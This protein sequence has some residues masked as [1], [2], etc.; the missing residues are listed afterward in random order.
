MNGG[1]DKDGHKKTAP[2][3][4]YGDRCENC[5]GTMNPRLRKRF[6][7]K[8]C[9][10]A[11]HKKAHAVGESK[12]KEGKIKAA[13]LERSERLQKVAK[14]LGDRKAYS[15]RDIII[16]CDV[17][18]VSAIADELREAKNGFD[19]Q[20]TQIKKDRWEY[21]MIGGFEH[22]KRISNEIIIDKSRQTKQAIRK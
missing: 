19:I 22:L 15:T 13:L 3:T 1:E 11:Y 10:D 14:L 21:K 4:V 20:C 2:A 17:C 12:L 8:S 5:G 18:A 16:I 9:K 7:H 6:C